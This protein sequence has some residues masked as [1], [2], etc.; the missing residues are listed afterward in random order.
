MVGIFYWVVLCLPEEIGASLFPGPEQI[1]NGA[2]A[3]SPLLSE[4]VSRRR[5]RSMSMRR[6]IEVFKHERKFMCGCITFAE[7]P[8]SSFRPH[9]FLFFLFP[10]FSNF[11]FL[12]G[13]V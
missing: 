10:I 6:S 13:Q 4:M 7:V 11:F 1:F 5:I 8:Q 3:L 9:A 2:P 12:L